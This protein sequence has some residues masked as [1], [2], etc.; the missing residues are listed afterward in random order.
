MAEDKIGKIID[1]AGVEAESTEAVVGRL[2]ALGALEYDLVREEEAT[3]LGVRVST[4]DA[5]VKKS[6]RSS[7]N[8]QQ[9][10]GVMF[11]EPEPWPEHVDGDDLLDRIAVAARRYLVLPQGGAEVIALWIL[12]AHAV[13][14]FHHTPRLAVTAPE[15]QCGKSVVLDFLELLTPKSL[16]TENV[17]SAVVFRLTEEH[18]PTLLCDEVDT[19]IKSRDELVGILNAGHK[20]GGMAFR[21]EGDSNTVRGFNVFAPVATA[22]IGKLPP[23]LGDRSIPIKMRRAGKDERRYP[24][25]PD[26]A[27]DEIDLK[28]MAMRWAADNFSILAGADAVVPNWMFNRAADNWRPLFAIADAA[29]AAWSERARDIAMVLSRESISDESFRLMALKDLHELFVDRGADYLLSEDVV[30][31][32]KKIEER[33]WADWKA[34]NGFTP[35]QLARLLGEFDIHPKTIKAANGRR[36]YGRDQCEQVFSAYTPSQSATPLPAKE[37]AGF[38]TPQSATSAATRTATGPDQIA[39]GSTAVAHEVA[40]QVALCD[41]RKAAESLASSGVALWQGGLD[42]DDIER[43]AIMNEA[44]FDDQPIVPAPLGREAG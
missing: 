29:S 28:R 8:G 5:E 25:R 9:G 12:H 33:P 26:R 17:T 11:R 24:L 43:D 6:R 1:D 2:A 19:Y 10:T 20:Q 38:S 18:Q 14:A 13:K 27:L 42:E 32:F 35:N 4:L 22:G 40:G 7:G 41:P 23:T 21:C 44:D 3:R 39:T 34:K 37:S 30:E 31:A 36:G 15:R 16:K